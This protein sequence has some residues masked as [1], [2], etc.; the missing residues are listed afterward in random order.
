MN[1]L[2]GHD[3]GHPLLVTLNAT[4]EIDPALVVARMSYDHPIHDLVAVRAQPRLAEI[5]SDTTV[6]AGAYHG[7]GFHED[8]ARSGVAAAAHFGVE[9]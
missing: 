5:A 1:K 4:D 8:G 3:A 2:Q 6:F 7:W 9:W